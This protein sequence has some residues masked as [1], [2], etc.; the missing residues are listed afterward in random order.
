MRIG[1]RNVGQGLAS[2]AQVARVGTLEASWARPDM[3][4]LAQVTKGVYC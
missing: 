3:E 2:E 4:E 1:H